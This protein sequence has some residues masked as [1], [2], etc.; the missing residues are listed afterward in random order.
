MTFLYYLAGVLLHQIFKWAR[1]KQNSDSAW[2]EYWK[3]NSASAVMSAVAA[4]VLMFMWNQGWTQLVINQVI[5]GAFG[6]DFPT[7]QTTPWSTL[8]AG[9]IF[10]SVAKGVLQ[11][12]GNGKGGDGT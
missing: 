8:A 9:Y 11:M 4:I 7:L 3:E 1:W 12:F 5:G 2:M 6:Q 10:D